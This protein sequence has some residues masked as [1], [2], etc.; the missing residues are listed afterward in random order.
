MG[1]NAQNP[2]AIGIGRFPNLGNIWEIGVRL[3]CWLESPGQAAEGLGRCGQTEAQPVRLTIEGADMDP[4]SSEALDH[5]RYV[6]VANQPEEGRGA[7]RREARGS[8]Q[9]IKAPTIAL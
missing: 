8:K 6:V 9:H 2:S 4:V 7:H 5:A 1:K 3:S